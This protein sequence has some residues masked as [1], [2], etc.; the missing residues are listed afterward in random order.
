M[1]QALKRSYFSLS[2]SFSIFDSQFSILN[3]TFPT[4][5][6]RFRILEPLLSKLDSRFSTLDDQSESCLVGYLAL[7]EFKLIWLKVVVVEASERA[8][9]KRFLFWRSSELGKRVGYFSSSSP[10]SRS[11]L[12]WISSLKPLIYDLSNYLLDLKRLRGHQGEWQPSSVIGEKRRR[13]SRKAFF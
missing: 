7:P 1:R 12:S 3:S 13:T 2:F 6:S 8:N 11:F 9:G 10:S 4:L 5:N